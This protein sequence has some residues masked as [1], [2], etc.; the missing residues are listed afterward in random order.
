MDILNDLLKEEKDEAVLLLALQEPLFL[1]GD[2]A[3]DFLN[4]AAGNGFVPGSTQT[5]RT[6]IPRKSQQF[7]GY[8]T[9][10]KYQSTAGIEDD[11]D[12]Q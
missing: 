6:R 8:G 1:L 11:Q 5:N 4:K 7:S 2:K 12:K 9:L 10:S 3:N